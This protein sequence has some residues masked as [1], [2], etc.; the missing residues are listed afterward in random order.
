MQQ[1]C[2]PTA[3]LLR[4]LAVLAAVVVLFGSFV[5]SR[6]LFAVILLLL[7]VAAIVN[8]IRSNRNLLGK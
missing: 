2:Y 4:A 1:S 6:G 3:R 5:V 8:A 7:L